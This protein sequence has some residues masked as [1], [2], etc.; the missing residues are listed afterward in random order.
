MSLSV[1]PVEFSFTTPQSV[2]DRIS[3]EIDSAEKLLGNSESE[4]RAKV[5]EFKPTNAKYLDELDLYNDFKRQI[6]QYRKHDIDK[7]LSAKAQD[8]YNEVLAAKKDKVRQL[9]AQIK[10]MQENKE[11]HTRKLFDLKLHEY[12]L[13]LRHLRGDIADWVGDDTRWGSLV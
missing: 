13:N 3:Y 4:F 2:K 5:V 1:N 8:E 9:N 11:A 7:L 10:D 12:I 6:K